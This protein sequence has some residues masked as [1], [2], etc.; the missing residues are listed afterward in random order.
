E[1]L[2]FSPQ[3]PTL[4]GCMFLMIFSTTQLASRFA[5]LLF[6]VISGA[7]NYSTLF[8]LFLEILKFLI[9]FSCRLKSELRLNRIY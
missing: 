9:Y 4:I 5:F 8:A 7:L 3:T 2:G 6:T 1:E